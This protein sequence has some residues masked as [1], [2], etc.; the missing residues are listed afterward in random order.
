MIEIKLDEHTTEDV[1]AIQEL[2]CF[3]FSDEAIQ[4]MYDDQKRRDSA[5][6]EGGKE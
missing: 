1:K 4:K 5:E 6:G 2:R 3:G